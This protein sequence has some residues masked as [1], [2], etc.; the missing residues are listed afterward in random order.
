MAATDVTRLPEA[1]AKPLR[2]GPPSNSK[3]GIGPG[4]FAAETSQRLRLLAGL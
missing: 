1:V 4:M 3:Q 2:T